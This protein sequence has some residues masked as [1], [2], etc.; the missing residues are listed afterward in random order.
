MG[1]AAFRKM[2]PGKSQAQGLEEVQ[3]PVGWEF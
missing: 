2:D 1:M 3:G